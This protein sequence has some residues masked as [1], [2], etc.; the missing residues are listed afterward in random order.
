MSRSTRDSKNVFTRS[1]CV[2][3]VKTLSFGSHDYQPESM[4]AIL[5]GIDILAESIWPFSLF[6]PQ[7]PKVYA[8]QI[9][10]NCPQETVGDYAATT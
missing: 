1:A 8:R 10:Y 2:R 6:I 7:Q 5:D 4:A 3:L 9:K